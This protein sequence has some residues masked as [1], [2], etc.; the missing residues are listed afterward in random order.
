[1]PVVK[2]KN[3]NYIHISQITN[4]NRD[5][6]YFCLA[7]NGIAKPRAI[8][9]DNKV[10]SHFYHIDAE[11]CNPETIFHN[12]Y[13]NWL[14]EIGNKFVLCLN[15]SKSTYI[16]KEV[17]L[18]K[19]YSTKFG[20]YRPDI[21]VVTECGKTIYFEVNY[22]SKKD[23]EEY[24]EKWQDLN[25]DVV[26]V[27]VKNLYKLNYSNEL[28]EFNVIYHDGIYSGNYEKQSRQSTYYNSIG[29][30]KNKYKDVDNK[31][32]QI[33][34]LDWFWINLQRYKRGLETESFMIE[35]FCVLE[36]LEQEICV[37]IVKRLKCVDLFCGFKNIM[38]RNIV[39]YINIIYNEYSQNYKY[40]FDIVNVTPHKYRIIILPVN[41]SEMFGKYEGYEYYNNYCKFNCPSC[42][43]NHKYHYV[44]GCETVKSILYCTN[45][46]FTSN[47]YNEVNNLRSNS[48]FTNYINKSIDY[49]NN[50]FIVSDYL[51]TGNNIEL[52]SDIFS[53]D[54][55]YK[56]FVNNSIDKSKIEIVKNDLYKYEFSK[57]STQ[58]DKIYFDIDNEI[59]H[60]RLNDYSRDWFLDIVYSG[61]L[62]EIKSSV[63]R[64]INRFEKELSIIECKSSDKILNILNILNNSTK[65][66]T[67]YIDEKYRDSII[68]KFKHIDLDK[69]KYSYLNR[70]FDLDEYI[71]NWDEY[72]IVTEIFL[73]VNKIYSNILNYEFPLNNH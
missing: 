65:L 67:Y 56:N 6:E 34:S 17:I 29:Q 38:N 60:S 59:C 64:D 14:F 47:Y 63:E 10:Q 49:I 41:Y 57:L 12:L 23:S 8:N 54:N 19:S 7:C 58:L 18:E 15:N 61:N 73:E 3:N 45:G 51:L 36:I 25:N 53:K 20:I 55:N 24:F 37:N 66:I 39:K 33:E 43:N 26:E 21:T 68:I 42:M 35:L 52:V 1:M 69:S 4:D 22:S 44:D 5:K 2:D 62:N 16:V 28:P 9:D 71:E 46:I 32:K 40:Y 48:K 30:Y 13:K 31:L 72:K 11:N 50:K 27:D 70:G